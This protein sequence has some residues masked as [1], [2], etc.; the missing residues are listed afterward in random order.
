[1]H[2]DPVIEDFRDALDDRQSQPHALAVGRAANVQLIE[3]KE[4]RIEAI[5]RDPAAGVPHFQAQLVAPAP[6]R[7]QDAA[8]VG[9]AAG[10]TEE[11]SQDPGHQAQVRANGVVAHVH[12]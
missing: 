9:V 11:V 7:Q 1:M 8:F 3:L 12:P 2:L 4:D 10:I 6:C 5:G